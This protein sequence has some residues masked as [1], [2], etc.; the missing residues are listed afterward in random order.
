MALARRPQKC[1]SR[2][3][4][5]ELERLTREQI[6]ITLPPLGF[7]IGL[8]PATL[9]IEI[10]IILMTFYFLLYYREAR[11]SSSFPAP[12]TLFGVVGRT[13][14]FRWVFR[15]VLLVPVIASGTLAWRSY[16]TMGVNVVFAVLT[17]GVE[18][19]IVREAWVQRGIKVRSTEG[20]C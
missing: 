16:W 5:A 1:E 9:I 15:M 14:L 11:L 2:A 7:P 8:A 20:R 3:S 18:C 13:P 6:G 12:A 17:L 10:G 19:M 4:P